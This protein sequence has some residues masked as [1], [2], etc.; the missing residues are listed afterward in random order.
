MALT[1]IS[2]LICTSLSLKY[3][4]TSSFLL[5]NTQE[6]SSGITPSLTPYGAEVSI[7]TNSENFCLFPDDL[8]INSIII[9]TT[10]LKLVD[11]LFSLIP[12]FIN[13]DL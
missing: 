4:T 5:A 11:S 6:K 8:S 3:I 1:I 7:S 13:N 9:L 2:A 12:V 10:S